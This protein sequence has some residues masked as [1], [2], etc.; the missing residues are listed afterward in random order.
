MRIKNFLSNVFLVFLSIIVTAI[1]L[2]VG[3]RFSGK[4]PWYFISN[5]NE[6]TVNEFDEKLGWK[7]KSGKYIFPAH[8]ENGSKTTFTILKDG[9]RIVSEISKKNIEEIILLGGSFSQGWAVDDKETYAWFLQKKFLGIKIANYAVGGYGTYQSLLKLEEVLKKK[10]N[11]K[12]IIYSFLRA[13][14]DR[15]VAD[16]EWL[17]LLTK[18]SKRNHVFLPYA[19]L[20]KNNKLIKRD[21]VKYKVLPFSDKSVVITRIQRVINKITL[22]VE[23][24]K[25]IK[26]TQEILSEIN[27]LAIKNGSQ[28]IFLNLESNKN[29]LIPYYDFFKENKI[30]FFDCGFKMTKELVVENEAHPN[31]KLH[32]LYSN[33]I[34]KNINLLK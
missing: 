7:P 27:K 19:G 14:E 18:Y 25:K 1:L 8:S 28:F 2:E 16:P 12:F 26:T 4:A 21:P 32:Q 22:K 5:I 17:R 9:N 3:L 34:Y 33:C 13:H 29:H 15:N 31:G 20:D 10:N 24:K 30:T 23:N 11:I 6:P